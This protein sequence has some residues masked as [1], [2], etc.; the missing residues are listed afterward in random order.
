MSSSPSQLFNIHIPDD[1]TTGNL[2]YFPIESAGTLIWGLS[3]FLFAAYLLIYD[4]GHKRDVR[5]I[6][7]LFITFLTLQT[8]LS[9]LSIIVT[10]IR[11][12]V[13]VYITS[14]ILPLSGNVCII[15]S[16]ILILSPLHKNTLMRVII[17]CIIPIIYI[18]YLILLTYISPSIQ[19]IAAFLY[20]I[21]CG[22]IVYIAMIILSYW[23]KKEKFIFTV[24]THSYHPNDH[25]NAK[26]PNDA[27][28]MANWSILFKMAILGMT[29][30][31]FANFVYPIL[32]R[33]GII[34]LDVT[35][36]NNPGFIIKIIDSLILL[37]LITPL[38]RN[39]DKLV[40]YTKYRIMQYEFG[41][42]C[43]LNSSRTNQSDASDIE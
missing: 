4:G 16:T 15:M 6:C 1:P 5:T 35:S 10:Y 32:L 42:N 23:Y 24:Y 21:P 11:S 14:A 28:N 40:E 31:V 2:I 7:G 43:R 38:I 18:S 36:P 33:F 3:S 9:G 22:L 12:P 26:N 20:F 41:N 37:P 25:S 34:D 19:E 27:H 39:L 30:A 17:I 8:L 13:L 29:I